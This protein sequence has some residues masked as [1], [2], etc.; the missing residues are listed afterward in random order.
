MSLD[1]TLQAGPLRLIALRERHLADLLEMSTESLAELRPWMVWAHP[2][3][4]R[5]SQ[6]KFIRE[7]ERGADE[8]RE[9]NF[10]IYLPDR[11]PAGVVGF[12]NLGSPHRSC[13]IGFWVRSSMGG[14]GICTAAAARLLRFGFDELD[15]HRIFVRHAVDNQRSRGVIA[16]LGF[17]HEGTA[18]D[19]L[20]I[21]DRFVSHETYAMLETDFAPRRSALLALEAA[22]R[23]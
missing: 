20:K 17:Q 5:E 11:R 10:V 19:D 6:L 7:S 4:T 16:K 2:D 3:P 14:R 23:A 8:G 18:R 1:T 21:G 22:V 15:L 9:R 12:Y 13:E